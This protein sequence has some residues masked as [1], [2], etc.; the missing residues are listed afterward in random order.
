MYHQDWNPV[1][2][3]KKKEVSLTKVNLAPQQVRNAQSDDTTAP[4]KVNSD[5]RKR[6]INL[7]NHLGMNQK[8]FAQKCCIPLPE[9]KAL[10]NGS[11]LQHK[12]SGYISKIFN[13][14]TKIIQENGL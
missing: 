7:R 12:A 3:N 14:H 13:S 2:L 11:L 4:E 6:I 9:Y 1:I 10:E 8:Q 5:K